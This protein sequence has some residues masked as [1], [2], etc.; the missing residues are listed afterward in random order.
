MGSSTTVTDV[1]YTSA[2]TLTTV[3]QVAV[4][5]LSFQA[6]ELMATSIYDIAYRNWEIA[7]EL[8]DFWAGVYGAHEA[9]LIDEVFGAPAYVPQYDTVEGRAVAG[10]RR[11]Y[12][13]Q[14]NELA[15]RSS[16]YC[17]K[18]T[19]HQ[20]AM[21]AAQEALAVGNTSA[22]AR[23]YEDARKE[24]KDDTNFSRK[25]Q[26]LGLGRGILGS[27]ASYGQNAAALFGKLGD[28]ASASGQGAIKALGYGMNRLESNYGKNSGASASSAK[29]FDSNGAAG[30]GPGFNDARGNDALTNFIDSR[31]GFNTIAVTP[32]DLGPTGQGSVDTGVLLG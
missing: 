31:N 21:L 9:Q 8:H 27:A 1:G 26:A 24:A 15:R 13:G 16:P 18:A 23:R 6:A 10:V 3:A 19:S 12:R 2:A 14:L 22:F 30:W 11:A 7:R 20:M 32:A 17:F 28:Q 5:T 29:Y 4:A 25:H